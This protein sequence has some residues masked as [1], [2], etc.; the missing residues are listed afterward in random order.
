ML[1]DAF[2][3]RRFPRRALPLG[4]VAALAGC[5]VTKTETTSSAPAPESDGGPLRRVQPIPGSV[6]V[7]EITSESPEKA[8]FRWVVGG[9]TFDGRFN[10]V[11]YF[12]YNVADGGGQYQPDEPSF[13]FCIE[14]DYPQGQ[15]RTMEAYWEFVTS[16]G[17]IRYRP[18]FWQFGRDT[19]SL[20]FV[21]TGDLFTFRAIGAPFVEGP[22]IMELGTGYL[23]LYPGSQAAQIALLTGETQTSMITLTAA[24]AAALQ[25]QTDFSGNSTVGNSAVAFT[26]FG[27]GRVT[28][29]TT[30]SSG[31]VLNVGSA[32]D[33]VPLSLRRSGKEGPFVMAV[34]PDGSTPFQL[35]AAGEVECG[36]PGAGVL[37]RSPDGTRHRVRV[38]N[39]GRILVEPA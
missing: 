37:L 33:V 35:T 4:A 32:D 34:G 38:D 7:A 24:G 28:L 3:N 29:G 12:G 26:F 23:N 2:W 13:A 39:E 6:L 27:S 8:P 36:V 30:D 1:D 11:S 31:G 16:D 10:S 15:Q 18:L 25:L 19:G 9:A 5:S 17:T 21:L 22:L 20:A 14:Q